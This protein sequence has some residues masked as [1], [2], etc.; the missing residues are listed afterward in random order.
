MKISIENNINNRL[1]WMTVSCSNLEET[2]LKEQLYKKV[3]LELLNRSSIN[4]ITIAPQDYSLAYDII[5]YHSRTMR[6]NTFLVNSIANC[7]FELVEKI[8][9]SE[10]FR[11]ALLIVVKKTSAISDNELI[12][13]MEL[14]KSK[15]VSLS[16]EVIFCEDDGDSLCLYNS[17]INLAELVSIS[18][19]ITSEVELS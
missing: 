5:P 15:A 19:S 6:G 9:L 10:E 4:L 8:V 2:L 7:D 13:I 3:L 12:E 11:R 17:A 14:I 18:K 16:E 1:I